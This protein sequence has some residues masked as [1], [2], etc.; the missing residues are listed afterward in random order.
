MI[1]PAWLVA[2]AVVQVIAILLSV[3]FGFKTGYAAY[4]GE[5]PPEI[6]F[7]KIVPQKDEWESAPPPT[8][9]SQRKKQTKPVEVG[10]DE[11][12]L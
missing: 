8:G 11:A 12:N 3:S 10:D 1:H 7:S 2:L 6:D 4:K 9:P 5:K